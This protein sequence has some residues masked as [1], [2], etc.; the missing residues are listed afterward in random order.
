MKNDYGMKW[1]DVPCYVGT[2]KVAEYK[3]KLLLYNVRRD[4]PM[5]YGETYTLSQFGKQVVVTQRQLRK[6]C[7]L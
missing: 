5:K 2:Y 4:R 1:I 3:G 6:W 7:G